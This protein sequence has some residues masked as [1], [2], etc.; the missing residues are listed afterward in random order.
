M[1]LTTSSLLLFLS[2]QYT[3]AALTLTFNLSEETFAF[4]GSD[5]GTP[6]DI[7]GN[8]LI[9]FEINNIGDDYDSAIDYNNALAFTTTAGSPGGSF[10]YDLRIGFGAT[11]QFFSIALNTD[12]PS[13]ETTLS[14]T[15]FYQSYASLS[16]EAK[17]YLA[18]QPISQIA[19]A[20]PTGFSDLQ[21]NFVPEPAAATPITAIAALLLALTQRRTKRKT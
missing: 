2:A 5:T 13:V 17:A 7:V 8:G 9:N 19:S 16:T 11:G 18:T 10:G 15:G 21:I 20:A 14:G 4:T 1:K 6:V 12:T 3:F